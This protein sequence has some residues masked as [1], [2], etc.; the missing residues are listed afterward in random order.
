M[1]LRFDAI[2]DSPGTVRH[3][4]NTV[5]ISQRRT[6]LANDLSYTQYESITNGLE[7]DACL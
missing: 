1:V 2:L 6:Q 7:N 3:R 4:T 5:N